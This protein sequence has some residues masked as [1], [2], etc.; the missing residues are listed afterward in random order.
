MKISVHIN[1]LCHFQTTYIVN[2]QKNNNNN[3]KKYEHKEEVSMVGRAEA[4]NTIA[5][6]Q[7]TV[8]NSMGNLT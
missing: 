6:N 4:S 7:L 3:N 1:D 8:L 5:C 2:K